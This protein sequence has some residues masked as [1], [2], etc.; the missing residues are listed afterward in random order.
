MVTDTM[1]VFVLCNHIIYVGYFHD[2]YVCSFEKKH[3]RRVDDVD[4]KYF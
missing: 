3:G 1:V 2:C 4:V